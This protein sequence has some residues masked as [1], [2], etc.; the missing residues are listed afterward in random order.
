MTAVSAI[1]VHSPF[2]GELVGTAPVAS[3]AQVTEALDAGAAAPII[4]V[5]DL[6]EAIRG[7]TYTKL[8]T[9][10]WG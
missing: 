1:A 4:R 5:R 10:P 9:L 3:H 6:D 8:Y 7:M 2:S